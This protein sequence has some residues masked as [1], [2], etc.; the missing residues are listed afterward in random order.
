MKIESRNT[1]LQKDRF[2]LESIRN[3][4]RSSRLNEET[5]LRD[6][7][8][9][10]FKESLAVYFTTMTTDDQISKVEKKLSFDGDDQLKVKLKLPDITDFRRYGSNAEKTISDAIKHLVEDVVLKTEKKFYYNAISIA[11]LLRK[12]YGGKIDPKK[13]GHG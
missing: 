9:G 10:W 5:Q 11:K 7:S 8:Q 13:S 3:L 4:I 1:L 6:T 2:I 12:M